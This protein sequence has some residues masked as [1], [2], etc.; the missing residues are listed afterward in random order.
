MKCTKLC[1]DHSCIHI[2]DEL[3]FGGD[4]LPSMTISLQIGLGPTYQYNLNFDHTQ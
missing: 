1:K 3:H 4:S 2:F